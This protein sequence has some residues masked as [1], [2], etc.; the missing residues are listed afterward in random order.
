MRIT[1]AVSVPVIAISAAIFGA[2]A[3]AA[4]GASVL[5]YDPDRDELVFKAAVSPSPEPLHNTRFA[6]DLGI[7]G[8]VLKTGKSVRA[9]DVRQDPAFFPG[10]DAM[11]RITE[12]FEPIPANRDLYKALFEKV[13]L[14]MYRRLKPI[15]DDIRTITGYPAES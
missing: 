9:D 8:Q 5:L 11:T 12:V 14:K 7:A 3:L 4:E 15:Y 1:A 13:Y 6:A 10:I 2:R